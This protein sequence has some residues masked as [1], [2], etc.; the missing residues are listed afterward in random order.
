MD[1][2]D[3]ISARLTDLGM[4]QADLGAR[5]RHFHRPDLPVEKAHPKALGRKA[6]KGRRCLGAL[7][8]RTAERG[9]APAA[10]REQAS[11]IAQTREER[12]LL[13]LARRASELPT[14]NTKSF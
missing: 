5:H 12:K 14:P 8:R 10:P 4:T 11:A 3:K 6:E 1:I 9:S 2:F 13:L 7:C